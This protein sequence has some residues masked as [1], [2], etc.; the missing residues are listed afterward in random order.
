MGASVL[1]CSLKLLTT[2]ELQAG[3][4]RSSPINR[5]SQGLGDRFRLRMNLEFL[6]DVLQMENNPV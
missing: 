5:F 2:A 4:S 3:R 1:T 6:I